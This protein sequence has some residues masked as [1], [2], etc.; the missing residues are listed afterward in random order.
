MILD[1]MFLAN[2]MIF[3][4]TLNMQHQQF[5]QNTL[6]SDLNQQ[7][8][9]GFSQDTHFYIPQD[10]Y[11]SF[12]KY[13]I[14]D[15]ISNKKTLLKNFE[16]MDG[17]TG[18]TYANCICDSMDEDT[19]IIALSLHMPTISQSHKIIEKLDKILEEN[20]SQNTCYLIIYGACS[21][22]SLASLTHYW[23]PVKASENANKDDLGSHILT[24]PMYMRTRN[25]DN[26][27]Q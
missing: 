12:H 27:C 3:A 1:P 15:F 26:I 25:K 10:W 22:N 17:Q 13:P 20:T 5:L 23:K 11:S 14:Q 4:D 24:P 7:S 19:L 6:Y 8:L 2:A 18:K 21:E 16:L 9:P